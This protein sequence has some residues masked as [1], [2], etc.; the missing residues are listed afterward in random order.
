MPR[1]IHLAVVPLVCLLLIACAAAPP[2]QA[3]RERAPRFDTLPRI[4]TTPAELEALRAG[5][6][7]E[8]V[9]AQAVR[10]GDALL[11]NPPELPEDFGSWIFYYACP[12]DGTTLRAKSYEEHECP[13]CNKVYSD[14][15]TIA[16]HRGYMHHAIEHAAANLGWAYAHTGDDRYA[17]GVK[18][19]L[20]H[21]AEEYET[22]PA[23]QDR[24]GRQGMF[25]RLGG[26]RYVQSLD[27]AVGVIR[28]AKGYD[29]TRQSEVWSDDER[30]AVE[31]KFFRAT[32][33][34]LLVFNQ[35][36]NNHQTWYNAGLMA[37]A[38]T[39]GDAALMQRMLTMQGGF[40][41]Q[42]QRSIGDD[43]LWYEGTMAYHSYALQAIREIVDIGRRA[44]LTLHLEP[45]FKS[46]LTGPMNVAYPDGRYPAINDSDPGGI[47]Q[48][49]EAFA[50]AWRV[51]GEAVFAQAYARGDANRLAAIGA[52][53]VEPTWPIA[54]GSLNLA[55]AGLVKLQIGRGG[56]TTC[57]FFDYGPHG[58]GH[59][60][61]DKLQ[62]MLYANGRE[63]LLDPGRLTYSHKEYKTWV[64]HTA[65]HNTVAIDTTSQKPT[66]GKLL[67]FGAAE[68]ATWA[69]AESDGAY[70]GTTL[71]RHLML[72]PTVLIDV[73]EVESD[74]QRTIDLFAHAQAEWVAPS[75]KGEYDTSEATL[76]KGD[77]YE[78]LTQTAAYERT[79]AHWHFRAGDARLG[80][81]VV[82]L[83]GEQQFTT[84][85]IGYNTRQLTPTLVR[86]VEA[87][88]V[89][90]VT[91]YDLSGD[92]SHVRGVRIDGEM[93]L[94]DTAAGRW[95]LSL[96]PVNLPAKFS[97]KK[98]K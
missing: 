85:G 73:F 72:T 35:G 11:A 22:Y 76:G 15:Q 87:D 26:R 30:E 74:R 94:V 69:S 47:G 86:R 90:F 80:V 89:R 9:K 50:W 93:L 83:E 78:H 60:H 95:T 88:A 62:I 49:D 51:Y 96:D 13:Q 39:L 55:D 37:I 56:D 57:V 65:A 58:G 3:D 91:V 17:A 19:I 27:E 32:A 68:N 2:T 54:A 29:L 70:P 31:E 98:K 28:L 34:T 12:D 84:R 63:W 97:A 38:S 24:W 41:D 36:I 67:A 48:F 40:Y 46:M 81:F 23:R 18:R 8:Q 25:A 14:E 16:A 21:L 71:R 59:G 82:P 6:D 45:R 52:A 10:T 77:G 92:E 4:A 53:E 20:L 61:A 42:L 75:D 44:G 66:T 43:G 7:Y 5:V 79:L 64:K 33:D 1:S